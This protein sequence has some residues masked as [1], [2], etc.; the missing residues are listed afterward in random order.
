M[1][2]FE[3]KAIYDKLTECEMM[4]YLVGWQ[5]AARDSKTL[6]VPDLTSDDGMSHAFHLG[7]SHFYEVNS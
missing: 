5:M 4:E 3:I 2:H 7:Y 6:A 1:T